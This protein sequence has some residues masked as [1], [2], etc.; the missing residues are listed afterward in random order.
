MLVCA[1]ISVLLWVT[2]FLPQTDRYSPCSALMI[3]SC[4]TVNGCT[5]CHNMLNA[6]KIEVEWWRRWNPKSPANTEYFPFEVDVSSKISSAF[7]NC[8]HLGNEENAFLS[9][10][11]IPFDPLICVCNIEVKHR[12]TGPRRNFALSTILYSITYQHPSSAKFQLISHIKGEISACPTSL[13]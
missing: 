13:P 11:T 5:K 7:P 3:Q 2:G 4:F 12:A 9:D 10:E 1:C 8:T 6:T